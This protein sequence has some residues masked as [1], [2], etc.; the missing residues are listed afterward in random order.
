[1]C[2][3]LVYSIRGGMGTPWPS[4]SR[5]MKDGIGISSN[6]VPTF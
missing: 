2:K 4:I 3:I 6:K 5:V 1:M